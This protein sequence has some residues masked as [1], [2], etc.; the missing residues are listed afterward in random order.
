MGNDITGV[1]TGSGKGNG[2]SRESL[3]LGETQDHT[4]QAP[5]IGAEETGRPGGFGAVSVSWSHVTEQREEPRLDLRYLGPSSVML[6]DSAPS[7][8]T[9]SAHPPPDPLHTASSE[10][11]PLLNTA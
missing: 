2:C 6:S 4:A 9:V 10:R 11:P 7:S 3:G 1:C 8:L 5:P